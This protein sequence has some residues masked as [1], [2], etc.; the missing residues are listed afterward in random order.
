MSSIKRLV[1]PLLLIVFLTVFGTGCGANE[2]VLRSGRETTVETN[3]A[4]EKT[5]FVKDLEAMRTA[6]FTFIYVLRRSDGGILDA[7]DVGVIKLQTTD[8]NR[9]VK[10]DNDR[11]VI[12]G[13]NNQV[14]PNNLAVLYDRFAVENY[15]ET[16][17]VDANGN[18]NLNK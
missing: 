9:R 2:T 13:T 12:I 6:R 3:I 18:A 11:A 5:S 1:I 8:T 17:V 10:T 7:D 14:P 4:N 15:S 16:S